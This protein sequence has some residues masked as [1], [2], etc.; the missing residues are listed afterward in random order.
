M[1]ESGQYG[2]GAELALR[3]EGPAGAG[4]RQ[5]AAN[6]NSDS[7]EEEAVVGGSLRATLV[8]GRRRG[9]AEGEAGGEGGGAE[10]GGG[11]GGEEERGGKGRRRRYC[12]RRATQLIWVIILLLFGILSNYPGTQRGFLSP[13][14]RG[15]TGLHRSKSVRPTGAGVLVFVGLCRLVRVKG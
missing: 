15:C 2:I 12:G 8:V 11:S 13:I 10:E 1:A 9:R 5:W 6:T 7:D 3:G 4:G 14:A